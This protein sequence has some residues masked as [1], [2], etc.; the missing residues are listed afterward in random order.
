MNVGNYLARVGLTERPGADLAG[1]RA[2]HRAHLRAVAFENLDQQLGRAVSL[3]IPAIYDKIVVRRRGGWC[4]EMNGIFGWALGE[5]GFAATRLAGGVMRE[6][7]GDA[8]VGNHLVLK[9]ALGDG[10]WFAD[11]GFGDGPHEPFRI[12]EGAFAANGFAFAL[13]RPGG[14][15]WRMHNRRAVDAGSYDVTLA[16]ADE[17]L[18]AARC[19]WLQSAPESPFMQNLVC[20]RQRARALVI[21]RGRV[22]QHVTPG[23]I[24]QRLLDSADELTAVLRGEF[25]LDVPEASGLWPKIRDRHAQLFGA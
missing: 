8:A 14:A 12:A 5:L 18:L 19:Q 21:L 4:Y 11:V 22:L 7:R 23:G 2:L 17:S 13:S 25:E 16:P 6:V 20:Q 9:V 15:W 10:D 24:E 1:L 3:E